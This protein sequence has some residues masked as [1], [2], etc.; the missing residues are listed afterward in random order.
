MI[1]KYGAALISIALVAFGFLKT[2]FAD[3]LDAAEVWQLVALVA[4]A[5]LTFLVPLVRGKW[6]GLLKTGAAALAA[7]AT[8]IVPFALQ[9]YLT[10]EQWTIVILAVLTAL[11]V[12]VGVQA[13]VSMIDAGTLV[14]GQPATITSL[15][16]PEGVKALS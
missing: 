14:P 12:E 10:P 8:A 2:A 15:P 4:G 6:A 16:D 3:N 13:R 7:A 1:Q 5:A 9:G 11:G